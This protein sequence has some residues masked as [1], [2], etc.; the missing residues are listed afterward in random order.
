[1]DYVPVF[2]ANGF[3]KNRTEFKS[4]HVVYRP[5]VKFPSILRYNG[6]DKLTYLLAQILIVAPFKKHTVRHDHEIRVDFDGPLFRKVFIDRWNVLEDRP[7]KN[8]SELFALMRK[9]V[10][11]DPSRIEAIKDLVEKHP[12]LIVFYNFDYE[13]HMLHSLADELEETGIRVGE[14]NGHRHDP[15]P[16]GLRWLYLVQYK[17]GGEAWECTEADAEVFYSQS[18][19]FRSMEQARGRIDRMI[20]PFTDLHYYYL[21]SGAYIDKV[22]ARSLAQKKDFNERDYI[23]EVDKDTRVPG[24]QHQ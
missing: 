16:D 14:W 18:Y 15:I 7:I 22:I 23:R 13:L 3:Y 1:M 2:I 10:N 17:A 9:I 24:L 5:Y 20:T 11:A 12:R 19:S 21:I 8:V 6:A 4:E